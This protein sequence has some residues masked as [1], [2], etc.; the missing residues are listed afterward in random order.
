MGAIFLDVMPRER[1]LAWVKRDWRFLAF[2]SQKKRDDW[3]FAKTA[4]EQH[5]QA[6][7][8]MSDEDTIIQAI[9]YKSDMGVGIY[10]TATDEVRK[11]KKVAMAAVE[12][13]GPNLR[14]ADSTL[15]NDRE[16][17]MK[18]L[19]WKGKDSYA[20]GCCLKY[21][22]EDLKNDRRVVQVAIALEG[23]NLQ[24]ASEDIRNDPR[25]KHEALGNMKDL[26]HAPED[27]RDNKVV[28]LAAVQIR[29]SNLQ[30]ASDEMKNTKAIVEAAILQDP[31]SIKFA[32][33]EMQAAFR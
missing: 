19:S 17:V 32:S 25:M 6:I 5:G 3:F 10:Q 1:A 20:P 4:V 8:L 2:L 18:A 27:W 29:G 30:Y 11:N 9:K 23:T 13:F 21:A 14:Y 22:S 31:S 33:E 7:R 16:L 26:R 15:Q 28:V 24:Y 12:M